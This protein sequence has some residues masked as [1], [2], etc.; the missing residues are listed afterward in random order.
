MTASALRQKLESLPEQE[1]E[2]A[3]LQTLRDELAQ[4]L[5]LSSGRDVNPSQ[6]LQEMGA[7]SLMAVELYNR[8]STLAGTKLPTTLVFDYPTVRAMSGFILTEIE[9]PEVVD[10]A[11]RELRSAIL[12]AL[13]AISIEEL[14]QRGLLDKL[15][16]IAG[17]AAGAQEGLEEES[18]DELHA[19]EEMADNASEEELLSL[20]EESLGELEE[21][22]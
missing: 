14:K 1:R 11:E 8:L 5:G 4:V 3:L 15:K 22:I 10:E 6:S 18:I 17:L 16:A 9:L 13:Q 19:L 21:E 2:V 20:L 12:G 7:D